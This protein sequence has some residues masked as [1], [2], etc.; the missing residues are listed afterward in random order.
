[1]MKSKKKSIE[2]IDD[3]ERCEW[4]DAI[5]CFDNKEFRTQCEF[6]S[7]KRRKVP[8]NFAHHDF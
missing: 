4:K 6:N 7:F 2:N 1:M 8:N 3:E 5:E